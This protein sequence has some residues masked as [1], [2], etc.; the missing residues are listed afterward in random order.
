MST[1]PCKCVRIHVYSIRVYIYICVNTQSRTS[2]PGKANVAQLQERTRELGEEVGQPFVLLFVRRNG[3]C[4]TEE[5][6][7]KTSREWVELGSKGSSLP[8][9]QKSTGG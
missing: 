2:S 8:Y 7:P 6:F 1:C 9:E 3:V 5:G 4:S